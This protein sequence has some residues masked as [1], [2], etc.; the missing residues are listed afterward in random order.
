MDPTPEILME[1]PSCGRVETEL[2]VTQLVCDPPCHG[3]GKTHLS[4]YVPVVM[5]E[6]DEADWWKQPA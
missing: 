6:P 5:P 1:C 2:T 4:D 3:C